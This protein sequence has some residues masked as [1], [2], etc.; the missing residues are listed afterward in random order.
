MKKPLFAVALTAMLA[1]SL[2]GQAQAKE[3]M[4]Y[5]NNYDPIIPETGVF[6]NDYPVAS[7]L[8]TLPVRVVSTPVGALVGT[9]AGMGKGIVHAEMVVSEHTFER[10]PEE[11]AAIMAPAGLVGSVVAAPLGAL[12]GGVRGFGQGMI[13]GFMLPEAY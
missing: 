13:S 6:T 12:N 3:D 10:I 11:S 5:W 9:V 8:L 2:S 4:D 1:V 7:R